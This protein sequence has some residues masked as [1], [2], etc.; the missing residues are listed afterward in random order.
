[1]TG[2]GAQMTNIDTLFEERFNAPVRVGIAHDVYGLTDALNSP[3]Y[4]TVLG[5]IRWGYHHGN[6]D[7]GGRAH[8]EGR[9]VELYERFKE[10]LREFLP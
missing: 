7:E 9:W 1:M 3:M 2:G 4:A 10:W 5:L 6:N 8:D